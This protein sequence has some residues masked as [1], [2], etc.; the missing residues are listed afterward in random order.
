MVNKRQWETKLLKMSSER[1][2]YCSFNANNE[3]VKHYWYVHQKFKDL[4]NPVKEAPVEESNA[5]DELKEPQKTLE[6]CVDQG[7][8]ICATESDG[9]FCTF[10]FRTLFELAQKVFSDWQSDKRWKL[11][12][13][14]IPYAQA[15]WPND[16]Y[17]IVNIN[18]YSFLCDTSNACLES[19]YQMFL[20]KIQ[21]L[22]F[23]RKCAVFMSQQERMLTQVSTMMANRNGYL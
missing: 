2:L 18:D 17:L 10:D 6:T 21:T 5:T 7:L 23:K 16:N 14:L 11:Y 22:Y 12:K 20:E 15:Y 19:I 8:W 3:L 13:G 4:E 1:K 9:V